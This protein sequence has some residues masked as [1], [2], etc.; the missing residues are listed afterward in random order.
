MGDSK[1]PTG[2]ELTALDERFRDDPYPVLRELRERSPVYEETQLRQYVYTRHDDVRAILKDRDLWS[3]PRKGNPGTL[4]YELLA[5]GVSD[6]GP[7]MLLM[8]D[9][10]HRRLRSLVSRFFTPPAVEKWRPRVREVVART[11]DAIEGP[12]LELI[13]RFAGPIPTV[14]IAE[15][16]GIDAAKHGDFKQWSDDIVHVS[17]NPAPTPEQARVGQAAH[18][19]LSAFFL[20]EIAA[21]RA[22]PGRDLLSDLVAAEEGDDRLTDAEIVKQCNLLLVAG[23]ITTT[24]LIGNGVKALLDHPDQLH[25]LRKE[26]ALIDNAVE[27]MLR[28]DSPV[29]DSGRIANRTV[30]FGGCPVPKGETL[31]TSLAAANR[32]PDVYPD[33]DA[34][35]VRRKD[36]HHQAFG[37]G[38]HMCLGA[39]LARVEVQ[40]AIGGLLRRHP[41]LAHGARGHRYAAVP[42]F[43]GLSELWVATGGTP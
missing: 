37:G 1:L 6:E 26:P 3:D 15:V 24:D 7:S 4:T 17:F 5:P 43:R 32:D 33:P 14:V 9:P 31:A 40:E 39:H 22:A 10:E 34:F 16:L 11:L 20:A 25:A 28:F 12:D 30:D 23:N 18:D 13:E 36:T 27:E 38:R 2:M 42:S 19:A 21:R 35:D 41:Q 8:D 29:T